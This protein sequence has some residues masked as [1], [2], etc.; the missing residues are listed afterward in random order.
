MEAKGGQLMRRL[1]FASLLALI[2][3]LGSVESA[4]AAQPWRELRRPH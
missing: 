4:N 3:A 2:A 1:A